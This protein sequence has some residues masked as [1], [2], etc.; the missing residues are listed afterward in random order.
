MKER[1]ESLSASANATPSAPSE[2]VVDGISQNGH[3]AT[4]EELEECYLTDQEGASW[5]DVKE[6]LVLEHSMYSSTLIF[7]YSFNH[8]GTK[9]FCSEQLIYCMLEKNLNSSLPF[10]KAAL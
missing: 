5:E 10:G 6:L 1:I 3:L 7:N 4:D 9:L 2:S 8:P